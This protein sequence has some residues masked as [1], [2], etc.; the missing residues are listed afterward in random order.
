MLPVLPGAVAQG[1]LPCGQHAGAIP[2]AME[3]EDMLGSQE[4]IRLIAKSQGHSKAPWLS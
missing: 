1:P 2:D 3:A 4:G